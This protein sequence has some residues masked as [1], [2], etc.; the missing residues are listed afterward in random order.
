MLMQ[1]N[2]L[3]LLLLTKSV[4]FLMTKQSFFAEWYNEKSVN[5]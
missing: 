4:I 5:Y 1:T 2:L 3:L